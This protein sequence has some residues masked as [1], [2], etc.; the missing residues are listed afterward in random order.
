[1]NWTIEG[2]FEGRPQAFRLFLAVRRYIES[3]GPV[4][5]AATKTQVSFGVKTKFAWVWL[6]QMWIKKRPLNTITLALDLDHKV[7]DPRIREAVEPQPGRWTHH[8]LIDTELDLDE[9]VK[10]CI[11][12]AYEKGKI[13]RRKQKAER[14]SPPPR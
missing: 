13:D 12:E 10:A 9:Q 14:T 4:E 7:N 8:I 1:M 11:R 6:P 2:L 5:V 3:I